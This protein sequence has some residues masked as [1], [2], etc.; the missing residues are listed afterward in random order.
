MFVR[1]MTN[2]TEKRI[3]DFSEKTTESERKNSVWRVWQTHEK[4]K[5]YNSWNLSIKFISETQDH[6][7][8]IWEIYH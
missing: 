8:L 1:R 3:W 5:N 2:E 6:Y 4:N 7:T